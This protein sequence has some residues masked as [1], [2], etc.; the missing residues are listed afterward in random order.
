MLIQQ[1]TVPE[2]YEGRSRGL[3]G[4]ND[5]NPDNDCMFADGSVLSANSTERELF[6]FGQSCNYCILYKE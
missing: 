2:K 6:P 1:V 5:G 3:L 4:N